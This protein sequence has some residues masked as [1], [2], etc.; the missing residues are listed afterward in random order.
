MAYCS[1]CGKELIGTQRF[2]SNCGASVQSQVFEGQE[3]KGGASSPI[4]A[5]GINGQITLEGNQLRI[6]RKGVRSFLTQGLRGDKDINA[7]MVSSVQLKPAGLLTNGF[8]QFTFF[9][10]Q[11]AKGGLLQGTS[12]ENTVFFNRKQQPDFE[13]IRSELLNR[14]SKN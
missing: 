14:Q 9:G 10:G 8:I 12:D 2:C 5:K 4:S 13:A 3:G 11:E 7:S 1:S 6:S